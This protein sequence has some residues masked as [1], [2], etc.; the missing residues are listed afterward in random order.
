MTRDETL[1]ELQKRIAEAKGYTDVQ[2][3]PCVVL[4]MAQDDNGDIR[5]HT[6]SSARLQ[7]TLHAD[8]G[9]TLIPR[10]P[11]DWC[12]AG[13]LV[14]EMRT[15]RDCGGYNIDYQ[16]WD[17]GEVLFRYYTREGFKHARGATVEEAASRVWLAWK[18][19][20]LSDLQ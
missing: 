12:A 16:P 10:W 7:G 18:G 4:R 2:E 1:R 14:E 6:R 13:E 20:D 9:P 3:E 17:D 11:W 15:D 8:E 5:A 19:V